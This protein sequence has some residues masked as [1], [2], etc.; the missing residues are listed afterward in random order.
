MARL[1]TST[2]EVT[3]PD[4]TKT[5]W[6]AGLSHSDAVAAVTKMIPADHKAELSLLRISRS[7]PKLDGIRY[8]DIRK[9]GP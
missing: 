1:A 3:A 5:L 9:V 4:G 8:G 7:S 6:T 2:V